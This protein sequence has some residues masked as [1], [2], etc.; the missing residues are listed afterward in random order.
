MMMQERITE[1][2]KNE[3]KQTVD[4]YERIIKQLRADN[5]HYNEK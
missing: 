3:Y 5:R 1:K 2:L 4:Q